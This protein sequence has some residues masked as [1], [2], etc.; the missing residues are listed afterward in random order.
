MPVFPAAFSGRGESPHRRWKVPHVDLEPASARAGSFGAGSADPVETRSRRLKSGWKRAGKGGTGRCAPAPCRI[1]GRRCTGL[2]PAVPV[3]LIARNGR[4]QGEWHEQFESRI[5]DPLARRGGRRLY[6]AGGHCVRAGQCRDP[7]AVDDA[8]LSAGC[9]RLLA[10]WLCAGDL[11]AAAAP[12]GAV[13]HAHPLS[14][15]AC[16]AGG[17]CRAWRAG[18]DRSPGLPRCRSGRPSPL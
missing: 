14:W 5:I 15:P 8:G 2:W 4:T 11:A 13:G 3:V 7:V 6:G 10:I 18:L 17:A 16:G 12:A 1:C 9:H